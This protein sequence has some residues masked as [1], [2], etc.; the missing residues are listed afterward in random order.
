MAIRV[1][2]DNPEKTVLYMLFEGRWRISE[3]DAALN[4]MQALTCHI[5]HPIYTLCDMTRCGS[6][7]VGILWQAR[8]AYQMAREN[9]AGT[10]VATQNRMVRDLLDSFLNAYAPQSVEK[11]IAV[12]TVEEARQRLA[13][14][15]AKRVETG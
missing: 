8:R 13:C 12:T 4:Q 1:S 9:W 3:F 15:Y 5:T 14:Q 7:P 10:V 11:I 6:P 2:W